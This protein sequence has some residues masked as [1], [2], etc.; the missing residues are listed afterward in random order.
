MGCQPG[1]SESAPFVTWSVLG[2]PPSCLVNHCPVTGGHRPRVP[3]GSGPATRG[4]PTPRLLGVAKRWRCLSSRTLLWQLRRFLFGLPVLSQPPSHLIGPW[5]VALLSKVTL[6]QRG[7]EDGTDHFL[8]EFIPNPDV[9][10]HRPCL[11]MRSR[12]RRQTRCLRQ[13]LRLRLGSVHSS[14]GPS[15]LTTM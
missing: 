7:C 6:L 4:V 3:E 10:L 11:R 9:G 2:P 5:V 15:T 13:Y 1:S 12:T 8:T 14:K